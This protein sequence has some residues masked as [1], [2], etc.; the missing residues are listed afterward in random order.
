MFINGF[1]YVIPCQNQYS[2]KSIDQIVNEQYE[3]MSTILKN[4]LKDHRISIK[5]EQATQAF[6]AIEHILSEFYRKRK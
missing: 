2:R 5:D 6:S 3:N 4:C 1:K